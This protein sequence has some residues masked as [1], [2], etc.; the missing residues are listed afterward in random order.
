MSNEN[1]DEHLLICQHCL[2]CIDEESYRYF[3]KSC[4]MVYH[5]KC[6]EKGN[7]CAVLS[8]S[9]RN[10]LLN[11]LFQSSVPVRELVIHIEYLFNVRK[12]NEAINEC[13]RILNAD[14]NN[15]EAKVFYNRAISMMN[16]KMKIHECAEL[17]FKKKEFKAASMFYTDY[18]K[19]CDDEES[20]FIQ[21]KIKYLSELLPAI[22]RSR[23][24]VNS[25][26]TFIVALII[27]SA[28]FLA[29]RFI[30]LKENTDFAEI[31]SYEDL[32]NVKTMESQITKYE[33]FL[34]KY[35]D[36]K[37][38]ESVIDKIR[39]LS[40][41]IAL[42]ICNDDWRTSLIYLR[43]IDPR[44]NP[45]TYK[46]IYTEILNSAKKEFQLLKSEAK[47]MNEN[48]KFYDAKDKI[49]KSL[50]LLDNFPSN[51]F[52]KERQAM[53]D[54]KNLIN[55]KLGLVI[56][57]KDIEKEIAI[58][59]EELKRMDPEPDMKNMIQLLGKVMKISGEYVIIK[60]FEDKKLY[61]VQ[62]ASNKFEIGEEVLIN[63]IKKGKADI[64]DDAGNLMLLPVI[65]DY[66]SN[67][68]HKGNDN[69]DI[70]IQRLYLLK[71][72]K[73][74]IDSLLKIGI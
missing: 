26:Y 57:V 20:E 22:K 21:S 45:V 58:K 19:Y 34:V 60:S 56:R 47:Y 39:K 28:G 12:F 3:C 66:S 23:Y 40:A 27:L 70:I 72:Q 74:K 46:E 69:K 48:K 30:Y 43:K 73:E 25:I 24:I 64:S 44:E 13:N 49:E 7:G 4:G 63:G 10:I 5:I 9:Q 65:Y 35:P 8:C 16:V 15:N 71:G 62:N 14:K 51:E 52:E 61:A 50:A 41:Q 6:W 2:I 42:S 29:Y 59:T 68:F 1:N 31:E 53:Y 36:G 32:S 54:S 33:K 55:K 37:L 17:S 11:P 18:L 38:K 67:Q